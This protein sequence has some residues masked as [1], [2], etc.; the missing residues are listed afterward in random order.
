M[1]LIPLSVT[2]G[3]GPTTF[4]FSDPRP[5]WPLL[6]IAALAVAVAVELVR[7]NYHAM[8]RASVRFKRLFKL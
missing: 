5:I 8:K 1:I 3:D 2:A 6:L 7:L 4:V